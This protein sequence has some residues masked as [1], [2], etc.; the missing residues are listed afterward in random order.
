MAITNA[1][2]QIIYSRFWQQEFFSTL[3]YP[4]LCNRRHQE[5]ITAGR[6]VKIPFSET[7]IALQDYT[8]GSDWS[9]TQ[10][11]VD[12]DYVDFT[13][14]QKK[15]N[16]VKI[17][18]DPAEQ[19]SVS[20]IEDASTEQGEAFAKAINSR[21]YEVMYA[22]VSTSSPDKRHEVG[23]A[24]N[25]LADSGALTEATAGNIGEGIWEA[26]NFMLIQ[27]ARDKVA[28]PAARAP[29]NLWMTMPPVV[30]FTLAEWLRKNGGSDQVAFEVIR[31]G[32]VARIGGI[33][34]IIL[35]NENA[36][37]TVSNKEHHVCIAGTNVACTFADRPTVFQ[38]WTP[39]TNQSGPYYQINQLRRYDA[40]IENATPLQALTVRS[41]A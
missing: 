8:D 25:Y 7:G 34:D 9:T 30:W 27:A 16:T 10:D 6:T 35:S 32:M 22:G 1:E 38:F 15:E 33:I 37:K 20:V 36:K 39:S 28:T 17:P 40:L 21:I 12:I 31:T 5:E 13:P 4:G 19:L 11:D 26:L 14:A 41:E 2:L 3:V 18:L 24:A 29:S 23:T